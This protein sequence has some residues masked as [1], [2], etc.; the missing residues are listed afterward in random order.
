MNCFRK[1]WVF[2]SIL[3][4]LSLASCGYVKRTHVKSAIDEAHKNLEAGDFQKALDTYQSAYKKYPKDS[5]VLKTYVETIESVK[6]QG[7]EAFDT[8]NFVQAQIKYE[9]LLKNL[10]RFSD[11]AHLL[12]FNEAYLVTRIKKGRMHQT[13]KQAESFLKA[14][15]F[16]G[17]IDI[18][19][20]LIQQYPSDSAVRNSYLNLLESIKRQ[21]DFD[22]ERKDLAAAGRSYRI[23]LKNHSSINHLKRFLSYKAGLLKARIETCRKIL[24]EEGLQQYRSGDLTRAI[25]TW[26]DILSFDPENQEVKKATDK[27]VFQ[28]KNL[29]K[30][31]SDGN[32]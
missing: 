7:D 11:F 19:K 28:S 12:S 20:S 22:F 5:E 9:L 13:E 23:L 32:R 8:N 17:G 2:L 29:K 27:A 26:R 14:R 10:P 18:Y 4:L 31:K 15:D 24:F 3:L 16:Q 6:N 1:I 25:S 30:I 21:A